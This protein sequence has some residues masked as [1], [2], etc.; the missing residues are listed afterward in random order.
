MLVKMS[1][2]LSAKHLTVTA[3]H[4]LSYPLAED[5]SAHLNRLPA[6]GDLVIDLRNVGFMDSSGLRALLV[7]RR[8]REEAGGSMVLSNPTPLVIR[9]LE[10]TGVDRV[11]DVH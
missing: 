5:F 1:E 3:P 2:P 7:E 11:L 10:V 8:R 9:L 4:E 6:E